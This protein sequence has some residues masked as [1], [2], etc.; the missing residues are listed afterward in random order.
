MINEAFTFTSENLERVGA[1][2]KKY[3]KEHSQ[4]AVMPLLDLAQAQNGGWLSMAA[5][6]QV[7]LM[8]NMPVIRVYEVA[9]FYSMYHLKPVGVHVVNICR[10]TPCW[11]KGSDEL[12]AMC[13]QTLGLNPGETKDGITL[14]EVE[15][16][17]A[18]RNAPVIQVN[19]TYIE[20]VTPQQMGQVLDELS[21]RAEKK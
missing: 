18:C 16:L 15:C 4:S 10:T 11:L 21:K 7:A 13:K 19:D 1:I 12:R 14:H 3:P 9:S 5:I 8:L 17:G 6:E 2:L 20:D